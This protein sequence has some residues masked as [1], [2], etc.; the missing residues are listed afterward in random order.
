MNNLKRT[1]PVDV[2]IMTAKRSPASPD[3]TYG[4]KNGNHRQNQPNKKKYSKSIV[5]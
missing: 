5:K 2:M 3:A 1:V 4:T